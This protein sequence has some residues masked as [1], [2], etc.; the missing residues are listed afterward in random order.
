V[1]SAALCGRGADALNCA[2]DEERAMKRAGLICCVGV[3][4]LFAAPAF[5]QLVPGANGMPVPGI[6]M[7]GDKYVDPA[8]AEKRKEIER[9]YRDTT[10]KIPAQAAGND[11]WANMRGPSE[12]KPAPAPAVKTTQKNAQKKK[13]QAQ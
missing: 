13:T 9:A 7:G 11:P 2:L 8:T 10:A 12:T 3:A 1:S 6:E 5:A 4:T